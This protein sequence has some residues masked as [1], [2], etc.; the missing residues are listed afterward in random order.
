MSAG[1]SYSWENVNNAGFV[2]GSGVQVD[3]LSAGI[4]VLLADYNNTS[5]CTVTD[6]LEVIEYSAIM[7][8]VAIDNVDCYGGSTGSILASSFGTISPYSYTWSSGQITPLASN[9]SAGSYALTVE[10]GNNCEREFTY[11]VTEPQALSVNITEISY[12]LTAGTPSG[13]TL[14]F[15]YSWR[16]QAN[17]LISLGSAIT[18][19]VATY[20]SYYVVV[21]DANGCIIESNIFEYIGTSIGQLSSGIALS[22][23]PNPFKQETTVDFGREVSQASLKVVDVFGKLIQEHSVRDTDKYILKREN[24]ASGIYFIEIEVEQKEKVIFKLSV[25]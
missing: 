3:S 2:I 5:G 23:Y 20:G 15:S 21:T 17:P 10:D 13:G 8:T 24:K 19:T 14:P 11:N 12:V 4:Y 25:N 16:E 18:Y 1:Y 9:L 6:T 22:I 7:N